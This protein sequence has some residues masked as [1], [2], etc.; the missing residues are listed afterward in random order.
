MT[1]LA[2]LEFQKLIS[3]KIC[4]IE[5][6]WNFHTV[7]KVEI[8]DTVTHTLIFIFDRIFWEANCESHCGTWHHQV[9]PVDILPFLVCIWCRNCV[10]MVSANF[11]IHLD[12]NRSSFGRV[13]LRFRLIFWQFRQNFSYLLCCRQKLNNSKVFN[14]W[15]KLFFGEIRCALKITN[16]QPIFLK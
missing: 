5:K 7:R 6:S 12:K 13:L 10:V 16:Q 8:W 4:V 14:H 3:H 1:V 2:L 9:L 15:Q 11:G